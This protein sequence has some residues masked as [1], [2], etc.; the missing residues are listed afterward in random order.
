MTKPFDG[1]YGVSQGFGENPDLYK[2]FLVKQPDGSMAPMRGH[3]GIDW[4]TPNGT[5][6]KAPFT[7]TVAEA[8]FDAA[9]YGN[10]VKLES[11]TEGVVLAHL[12]KILVGVGARVNAGEPVGVSDNTGYSTGPHLHLGY[13]RMPRD[14][15]NGYG[16]F[17]DPAPY[18]DG[19]TVPPVTGPL[20]TDIEYKSCMADREKFWKERD[21]EIEK[22]K[23]LTAELE[24]LK[25][26]HSGFT[27]LGYATVDDV[28]AAV[29]R[30]DDTIEGLNIQLVQ[31]QARNKVLAD[32]IAKKEEDDYTAI[33]EGIRA[34][35]ERDEYKEQLRKV[36]SAAGVKWNIDINDL[37]EHLLTVNATIKNLL[38]KRELAKKQS[39]VEQ[40]KYPESPWKFLGITTLL[41]VIVGSV[42]AYVL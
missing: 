35:K 29:K 37:V 2:Q 9:G 41:L 23:A 14:R 34:A 1:D 7:G 16:G 40:K 20:H 13:Y 19:L 38:A 25:A 4:K 6:I 10:Y 5:V 18:L 33:Q 31:V 17:I 11:D 15:S 28:Q 30:R 39:P 21:A 3:N 8:Y 27:A 24:A 32:T 26:V 42:L 12:E 22:T 36:K